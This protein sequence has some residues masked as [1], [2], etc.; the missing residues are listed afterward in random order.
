MPGGAS[1]GVVSLIDDALVAGDH[2]VE[3]AQF[4]GDDTAGT[5]TFFRNVVYT[6]AN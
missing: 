6:V 4:A 1:G 2:A 3:V 5:A